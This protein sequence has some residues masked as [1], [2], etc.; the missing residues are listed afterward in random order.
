MHINLYAQ[1]HH[2]CFCLEIT[3]LK[4]VNI[5]YNIVYTLATESKHA[6]C[7]YIHYC[8]HIIMPIIIR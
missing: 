3:L 7:L 2:L 5:N 1:Q 8:V 6:V 4:T